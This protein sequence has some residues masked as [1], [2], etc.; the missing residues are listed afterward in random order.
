MA[1]ANK[2]QQTS[3]VC[4]VHNSCQCRIWTWRGIAHGLICIHI[5]N[6]VVRSYHLPRSRTF[7][8]WQGLDSLLVL[9]VCHSNF[10]WP[11]TKT[12]QCQ[13]A[14]F[15]LS[16]KCLR[17]IGVQYGI[18]NQVHNKD[19]PVLRPLWIMKNHEKVLSRMQSILA[20]I[21]FGCAGLVHT[22]IFVKWIS[23]PWSNCRGQWRSKSHLWLS[24]KITLEYQ[25]SDNW[26]SR[27]SAF[28]HSRPRMSSIL[29][30]T[31][32]AKFEVEY[33]GYAAQVCK[34]IWHSTLLLV[35]TGELAWW[36]QRCSDWAHW[37]W[38]PLLS[39]SVVGNP[40]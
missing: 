40:P 16:R 27:I 8:S 26:K 36:L 19:S 23:K 29:I 11:L 7:I 15:R 4:F 13:H 22:P 32:G 12:F 9:L 39:P 38:R 34:R 31:S 30:V 17:N 20:R 1:C 6:L 24:L 18:Q 28:A 33:T 3:S 25:S 10:F 2:S 37:S 5:K 35:S 21:S 14:K